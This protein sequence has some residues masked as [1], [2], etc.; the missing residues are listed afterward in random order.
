MRSKKPKKVS[1]RRK[2]ER[3]S[4]TRQT[5]HSV[6]ESSCSEEAARKIEEC[7]DVPGR[8]VESLTPG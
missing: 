8:A 2:T 4:E 1:E 5:Q 7:G 6:M 3:E